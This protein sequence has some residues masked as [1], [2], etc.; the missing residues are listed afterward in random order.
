[1]CS[2]ACLI[3]WKKYSDEDDDN[4]LK[5]RSKRITIY[6]KTIVKK[7]TLVKSPHCRNKNSIS[8]FSQKNAQM[9]MKIDNR[10]Q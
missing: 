6:K 5:Q 2:I 4:N 1:M 3:S 10:N 7:A 8:S 9:M